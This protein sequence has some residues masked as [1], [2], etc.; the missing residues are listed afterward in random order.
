[1]A[2]GLPGLGLGGLFFILS[3]LLAPAVELVRTARGRSSAEAWL[4]VARNFSLAVV[5]IVAIE[6]TLRLVG[7]I[8]HTAG[9]AQAEPASHLLV[10]P[11]LPV[12]ITLGLLAAVL[13]GAKLLQ[14]AVPR[15]S[16]A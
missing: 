11:L 14:L 13:A 4:G 15:G 9:A 1:V 16:R 3:A 12:G 5:M 8:S 2:A 10:L 7:W 6:F